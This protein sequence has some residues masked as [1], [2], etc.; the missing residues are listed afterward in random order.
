MPT[1]QNQE[2]RTKSKGDLA[3]R[4]IPTL[5]HINVPVGISETV[6]HIFFRISLTNTIRSFSRFFQ[7]NSS[8]R[9]PNNSQIDSFDWKLCQLPPGTNCCSELSKND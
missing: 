7:Y 3:Q 4:D 5:G 6:F 9:H 1:F 2:E 8:F